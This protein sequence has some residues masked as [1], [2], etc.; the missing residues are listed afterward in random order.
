MK[1][2][3][4]FKLDENIGWV[5]SWAIKGTKKEVHPSHVQGIIEI[6]DVKEYIR[7]RDELFLLLIEGRIT[8]DKFV[9]MK[10]KLAGNKLIGK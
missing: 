1:P 10:D 4:E 2:Q 3:K 5:H 6:E 9:R 7:R 8:L